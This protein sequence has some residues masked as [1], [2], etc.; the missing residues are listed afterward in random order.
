MCVSV[1]EARA[2]CIVN[3]YA[4]IWLWQNVSATARMGPGDIG[5]QRKKEKEGNANFCLFLI[6]EIW[7]VTVP[8]NE[9]PKAWDMNVCVC[10]Y[11][12]F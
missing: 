5:P 9:F 2:S 11:F 3:Y 4:S 8:I 12:E 1:H 10:V 7:L 6:C